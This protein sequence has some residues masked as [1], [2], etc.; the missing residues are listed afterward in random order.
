MPST[1]NYKVADV[2]LVAFPFTDLSGAKQRPAVVLR[3]P[4][5]S[6]VMV[7]AI[8]SQIPLAIGRDE[9][10]IPSADLAACGLPKESIIR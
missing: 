8:T 5:D 7:A 10:E 9:F 4:S 2:V 6:D 1:T 3:V